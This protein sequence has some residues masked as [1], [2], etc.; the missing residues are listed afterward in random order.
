MV[1]KDKNEIAMKAKIKTVAFPKHRKSSRALMN[2]H[3]VT[4]NSYKEVT[5]FDYQIW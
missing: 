2:E 5:T 4:I 3:C 1:R